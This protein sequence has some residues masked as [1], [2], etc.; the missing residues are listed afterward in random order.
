MTGFLE[1]LGKLEYFKDRPGLYIIV[2][3]ILAFLGVV[4]KQNQN[5]LSLT[6][7]YEELTSIKTIPQLKPLTD[8]LIE[9]SQNPAQTKR[10]LRRSSKYLYKNYDGFLEI[11]SENE[12]EK[13]FRY[14]RNFFGL[15]TPYSMRNYSNLLLFLGVFH[16]NRKFHVNTFF[17][18]SLYIS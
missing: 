18:F 7:I 13:V 8:Q 10:D 16:K 3:C 5:S 2:F 11:R 1:N 15:F 12:N 6:A 14:I 9:Y 17:T 4:F